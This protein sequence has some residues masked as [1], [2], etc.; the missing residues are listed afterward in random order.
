MINYFLKGLTVF[1]I[2][3]FPNAEIYIAIPTGLAM[4]LDTVSTVVWGV[5]GNFMPI[6]FVHYGYEKL[7]KIPRL[8]KWLNRL[9]SEKVRTKVENGGFWFYLIMTPLMGTWVMGL[10]VKMLQI[11]PKK[12]FVPT[13]LSITISALLI[14]ILIASGLDWFKS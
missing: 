5:M 6:L 9:A 4:G 8:G 3:F 11:H 13:F 1:L 10:A 14:A 12:F 2:G 7:L